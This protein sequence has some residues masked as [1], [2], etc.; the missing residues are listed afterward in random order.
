MG[1]FLAPY[2]L[3]W[4]GAIT[5]TTDLAT[6]FYIYAILLIIFGVLSY[7]N[8]KQR[9]NKDDTDNFRYGSRN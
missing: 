6:P 2:L 9:G 3:Q 8:I 7:I 4:I 1:A 5:N